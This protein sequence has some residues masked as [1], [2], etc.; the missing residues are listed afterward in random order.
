LGKAFEALLQ[1]HP[2]QSGV[3][4]LRNGVDAFVGRAVLASMAERTIDVQ[5]YMFHQDTVGRLLIRELLKAADRG[6]RVRMLIDD[7]YGEE[8]DDVWS[9][10]DTH[11]NM[12][13]RL[14]NP[15]VRGRSKNAQY[16]FDVKR[17]NYRMHSKTYTV[18]NQ[19]S[20]VGGRN[21]GDEY[22]D[23][24][25]DV[26]FSDLDVMSIGPVV[27]EVSEEFD[28]YWNNRHSYPIVT[29]IAGVDSKAVKP[30]A[31]DN[32]RKDLDEFF[33]TEQTLA[34]RGAMKNSVFANAL[35]NKTAQFS[36]AKAKI[37]HDSA[38]KMT[39]SDED[40][41]DELLISQ[42]AP[43]IQQATE[44]FVLVSP[45]FVPGQRGADA[46]CKLSENGVRV[47]ILTNSLVSNDVA[48]VHTG[49]MRHRKQL[50]R[51]GVEVYE[52]NE[53]LKKVEAKQFTWLPGL[54]KSSL[55]AKT[56]A[57]DKQIMFVGSFNFDQRSLNINTEIGILFYDP[58]LAGHSSEHF[59]KYIDKVAFRVGLVT[60]EKGNESM[61]W[62]GFDGG[63][64]V[65][66]DSEPYA[67]F[68]QKLSV[69]LMRVLPI[70]SML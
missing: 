52:L 11:P 53:Q 21:I 45:Y 6:V 59:D 58:E 57:M 31:L 37:I 44:E 64:Q 25:E 42:L 27:P 8:A 35:R 65:V 36:Y 33:Q 14:F 54:S 24:D 15:F 55:H 2:G 62:T 20:I 9:A 32:L 66:F 49:Y 5:Y 46:I 63:K 22:F 23:A 38:E 69:N 48:A 13:V 4:L 39:R 1:E 7:M 67:S 17:V 26:A 16:I 50:L 18:D 3:F 29:L 68:W 41:K 43:Y 56:M 12:E 28:Q 34:Y 40:W 30:G 19:V 60:D 51:C 61:T 70:D 10:L 47:R